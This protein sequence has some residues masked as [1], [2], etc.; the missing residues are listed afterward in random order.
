MRLDI[1]Q[2]VLYTCLEAFFESSN[3]VC[4][5][6]KPHGQ[7]TG[8][9]LHL[10]LHNREIRQGLCSIQ[11]EEGAQTDQPRLGKGP[12]VINGGGSGS[13]GIGVRWLWEEGQVVM[14]G[15]SDGRGRGFRWLWEGVQ[16]IVGG[17]SGGQ[18]RRE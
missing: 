8:S 15:G 1:F 6:L 13:C 9:H 7:R 18:G 10:Y 11:Q 2:L 14:G 3:P 4:S 16:V 17:G 5:S 12:K